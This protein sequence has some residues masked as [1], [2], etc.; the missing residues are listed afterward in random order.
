[1]ILLFLLLVP[2]LLLLLRYLALSSSIGPL[3]YKRFLAPWKWPFETTVVICA[4]TRI[5]GVVVQLIFAFYKQDD[6]EGVLL[7]LPDPRPPLLIVVLE[8]LVAAFGATIAALVIQGTYQ[9]FAAR[10]DLMW[11]GEQFGVAPVLSS[12][13]DWARAVVYHAVKR[14]GQLEEAEEWRRC[15][16]ELSNYM[17]WFFMWCLFELCLDVPLLGTRLV[18]GNVCKAYVGGLSSVSRVGF[19]SV[20]ITESLYCG[21]G[22]GWLL[23]RVLVW[24]LAQAFVIYCSFE[25][26][27]DLQVGLAA[28]ATDPSAGSQHLRHEHHGPARV[29]TALP[30][31][32][33]RALGNH[34]VAKLVV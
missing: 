7:R 8:L 3:S 21:Y 12:E 14:G 22:E 15:L 5:F 28:A 13:P 29:V 25:A 26:W 23:S 6:L 32:A 10:M 9:L 30:R 27:Q 17:H 20:W 33:P 2:L 11:V 34:E 4:A 19:L 1:M 31:L 24:V 16:V 18:L